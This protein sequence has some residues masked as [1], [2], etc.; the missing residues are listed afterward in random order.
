MW[1]KVKK[2]MES[3]TIPQRAHD[4]DAGLDMFTCENGCIH[5]NKDAIV[6]TGIS[7]AI[8]DGWVAVV[9]EK[10]G[11]ATK[12]KLTIGACVIDSGYRGEILIHIF[13]NNSELPFTYGIGEKIAQLVVV[14]CW[15]GQPEE[16]EMLDETERGEGRF[17][18]TDDKLPIPPVGKYSAKDLETVEGG[19]YRYLLDGSKRCKVH[20][21]E[22]LKI[23]ENEKSD[24]YPCPPYQPE[25]N[26][27]EKS[28]W[29]SL[30]GSKTEEMQ[31][32]TRD[33][34]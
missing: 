8:P 3:A 17:G 29:K 22:T 33:D 20:I 27:F 15:T 6:K 1:M 19:I 26:N 18:S 5:A 30:H 34:E 4:T 10:S 25:R 31:L 21:T 32:E 2:L 28:M 24:D 12:N 16:V 7:I 13:N 9:K 23:K 14:P 11:R